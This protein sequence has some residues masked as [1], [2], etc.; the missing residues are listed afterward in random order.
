MSADLN[1]IEQ[2]NWALV[3]TRLRTPVKQV[4]FWTVLIFGILFASC[5]SLWIEI[6]NVWD[7]VPT[8]DCP[9]PDLGPLRLAYATTILALAA[10]CLAQLYFT[11]D[12]MIR[13]IAFIISFLSLGL[14]YWVSEN[15][16][17]LYSTHGIGILGLAI[18][19]AAWWLA[20]GE[21]P[22]LQD[23]S[24]TAAGSGGAD[25]LRPLKR[26]RKGLKV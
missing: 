17:G 6:C 23:R 18:S 3:K 21:D 12:K 9:E 16:K 14:A 8:T 15:A 1:I 19:V 20:N 10:P 11:S 25:L 22:I 2:D 24:D 4:T 7:F 26:N 13:V 5:L